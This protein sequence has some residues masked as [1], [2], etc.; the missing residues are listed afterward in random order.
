MAAGELDKC[1]GAAGQLTAPLKQPHS[2]TGRSPLEVAQACSSEATNLIIAGFGRASVSG[3]KG[4]GNVVTEVDFAVEAVCKALLATEFPNHA[5]LSEE[6][7]AAVRDDGW[8][9]VIDPIDGTKNF[10]RGIPHFCFTIALCFNH[11][12][13]VALTSHPLLH[14]E[15]S[16]V[17]GQGA[18][19]NGQRLEV[20]T[21]P[22]EDVVIA[23]D[24]GT[25]L[26]RD[27]PTSNWLGH[28]GRTSLLCEYPDPPRSTRRIWQPGD[29]TFTRTRASSPGI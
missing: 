16:A 23:I 6:T 20:S 29:G 1:S 3:I 18:T 5:I 19:L 12:P 28:C 2:T 21:V 9:W 17:L 27:W 10:S 14:E 25:R 7:S 4:R 11:E 26:T 8:M 22:L 15:F 24:L 13:V